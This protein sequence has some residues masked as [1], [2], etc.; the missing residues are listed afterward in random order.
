MSNCKQ[1]I[2]AMGIG[3]AGGIERFQYLP[4]PLLTLSLRATGNWI[5]VFGG[6]SRRINQSKARSDA[7]EFAQF[8]CFYFRL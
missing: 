4:I 5:S 6:R 1:V 8:F 3:V 2:G 7:L